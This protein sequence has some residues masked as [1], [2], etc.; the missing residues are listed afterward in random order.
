[1]EMRAGESTSF[2]SSTLEPLSELGL[3]SATTLSVSEDGGA[4]GADV[5]DEVQDAGRGGAVQDEGGGG[6]ASILCTGAGA[7][8]FTRACIEMGASAGAADCLE[9]ELVGALDIS[10]ATTEAGSAAKA[11]EIAGTEGA[12]VV[13]TRGGAATMPEGARCC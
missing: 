8:D 2:C 1:L 10:A 5:A 4:A 6:T 3:A 13:S 11:F 12:L 7:S 9:L